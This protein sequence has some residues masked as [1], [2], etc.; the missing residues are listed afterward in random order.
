MYENK[1]YYKSGRYSH[2]KIMID[3]QIISMKNGRFAETR[4]V[5]DDNFSNFI[6]HVTN[7]PAFTKGI[8]EVFYTEHGLGEFRYVKDKDDHI[9]ISMDTDPTIS[10]IQIIN[11]YK[12]NQYAPY[13]FHFYFDPGEIPYRPIEARKPTPAMVWVMD[14][15]QKIY[16]QWQKE[17]GGKE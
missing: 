8:N 17:Q 13:I 4:Q 16:D 10:N 12:G 9:T 14:V 6:L 5:R 2:Y 15:L 11:D 7:V 3:D 1:F